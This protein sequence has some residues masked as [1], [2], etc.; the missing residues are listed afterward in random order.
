MLATKAPVDEERLIH[1]PLGVQ[2]RPVKSPCQTSADQRPVRL[3]AVNR[4]LLEAAVFT[5]KLGAVPLHRTLFYFCRL[6][7]HLIILRCLPGAR[8]ERFTN[9]WKL[10]ES[11]K[12]ARLVAKLETFVSEPK[13]A[14]IGTTK[15]ENLVF[16]F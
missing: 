14:A 10:G 13:F 11:L 4:E 2:T 16:R 15:P 9:S 12:E 1:R 8:R 6:E 3:A 7:A 5:P